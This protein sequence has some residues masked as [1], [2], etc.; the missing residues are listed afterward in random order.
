MYPVEPAVYCAP[1]QPFF[2]QVPTS[3]KRSRCNSIEEGSKRDHDTPTE[4][5]CSLR[6]YMSYLRQQ[7]AFYPQWWY[8]FRL[9]V[10]VVLSKSQ[11]N[12]SLCIYVLQ[13]L[14]AGR[15]KERK[16]LASYLNVEFD[17]SKETPFDKCFDKAKLASTLPY[18]IHYCEE[19]LFLRVTLDGS[20]RMLE[21]MKAQHSRP[22]L[23]NRVATA[24]NSCLREEDEALLHSVQLFQGKCNALFKDFMQILYKE[25]VSKMQVVTSI[26]QDVALTLLCDV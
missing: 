16:L 6:V 14:L 21:P 13:I 22:S 4:T 15:N 19:A 25:N 12:R 18:L 2:H 10:N 7:Y 24:E 9:L 20:R 3:R 11:E 26:L 1:V 5:A 17:N 8:L 23:S